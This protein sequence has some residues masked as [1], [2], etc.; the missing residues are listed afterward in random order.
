MVDFY[1]YSFIFKASALTISRLTY[2]FF[3]AKDY[4]REQI[5]ILVI[6]HTLRG[7]K[8]VEEILKRD[9]LNTTIVGYVD[10]QNWAG[11]GH[12]K[13]LG[14]IEN[15]FELAVH[16]VID[17]ITITKSVAEHEMY[18][19]IIETSLDMGI[20]VNLLLEY[21]PMDD[22]TSNVEMIGNLPSIKFHV[23][24]LNETQRLMKRILD[25]FIGLIGMLV[26]IF[27]YIILG[28][29]IKLDSKGPIIFKQLRVGRHGRIFEFYKFRSMVVDAEELKERLKSQNEMDGKMFKIKDDPRITRLGAFLRK[30]SLDEFPQFLNVLKGDMSIVGTRPPTVEE[31]STYNNPE[32]KRISITPGITGLWQTSGRSEIKSFEDVL[33]FDSEYILNWSIWLDLYIIIKTIY[34]VLFSHGSY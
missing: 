30:S 26:F 14:K 10:N 4:N 28:P 2:H 8:Y 18:D 9:Y 19:Q 15:F 34:V 20:T 1:I 22:V 32:R 23:V 7:E 33:K 27:L 25:V 5:N 29:L 17:E 16:S 11:Y 3:Y 31:V 24:S 12:I 21:K 6:G 13:H